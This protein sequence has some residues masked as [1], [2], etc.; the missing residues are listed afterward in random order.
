M[1]NPNRLQRY[2]TRYALGLIAGGG[3]IALSLAGYGLVQQPKEVYTAVKYTMPWFRPDNWRA[4]EANC[5]PVAA[6]DAQLLQ[7][8]DELPP[9]AKPLTDAETR[10]LFRQYGLTD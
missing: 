4:V 2:W 1:Q 7:C 6:T 9:P 5:D 8:I 10:A 3:F